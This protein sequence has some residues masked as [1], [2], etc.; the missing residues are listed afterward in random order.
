MDPPATEAGDEE[1]LNQLADASPPAPLGAGI[2]DLE[3]SLRRRARASLPPQSPGAATSLEAPAAATEDVG[4]KAAG[5]LMNV[6]RPDRRGL[7]GLDRPP[8]AAAARR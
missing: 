5:N 2:A 8:G 4:G 3:T 1:L 7:S 6:P